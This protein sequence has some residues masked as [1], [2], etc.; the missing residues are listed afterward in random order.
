MNA[1]VHKWTWEPS[2]E[3]IART[4]VYRFMQRLGMSDREE[5][6]RWSTEHLEDFWREI[7]AETGIHWFVP[8]GKV[9]DTSRGVEWSHL[10]VWSVWQ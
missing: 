7:V 9:L 8:F 1:G 10:I 5:F 3:W 2:Q 6:L 4:N